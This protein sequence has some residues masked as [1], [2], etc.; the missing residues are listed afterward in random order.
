MCSCVPV[1]YQDLHSGNYWH[2]TGPDGYIVTEAACITTS[3]GPVRRQDARSG[4]LWHLTTL[5]GVQ[6]T[7]S[8]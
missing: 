5:T 6:F 8:C 7:Q 1:R 2:L 3:Y 4:N